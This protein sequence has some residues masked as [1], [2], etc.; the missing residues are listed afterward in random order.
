MSDVRAV[1]KSDFHF[2][3]PQALIAQAPLKE[4]SASRMLVL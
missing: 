4:R 3:L 2:D 1:K